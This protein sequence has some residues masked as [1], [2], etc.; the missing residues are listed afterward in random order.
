MAGR[1]PYAWQLQARERLRDENVILCVPTGEGKTYAACLAI[2]DAL[3]ASPEKKCIFTAPTRILVHQ[4][5]IAIDEYF[6]GL[7]RSDDEHEVKCQRVR[8]AELTAATIT[9]FN[10]RDWRDCCSAHNC[11]VGTQD[12]IKKVLIENCY[13]LYSD[14]SLF[15]IDECHHAKGNNA[16]VTLME[17]RPKGIAMKVLGL[18]ASFSFGK[19]NDWDSM[20]T[21]KRR[22][23]SLIG[24]RIF[25]PETPKRRE[26]QWL[27]VFF[28]EGKSSSGIDSDVTDVLTMIDEKHATKIIGGTNAVLRELGRDAF[29]YAWENG[30]VRQIE[31][32][33]ENFGCM[34]DTQSKVGP[35]EIALAKLRAE[36]P[37]LLLRLRES[38]SVLTHPHVSNKFEV[39]LDLLQSRLDN[40][41]AFGQSQSCIIFV[42]EVALAFPLAHE[43]GK[44]LNERVGDDAIRIVVATGVGSMKEQDRNNAFRQFREGRAEVMVCTKCAEEG[45][46]VASCDMVV[47]FQ[48]FD[49]VTSHIQGSGR[50]RKDGACIYYFENDP[51]EMRK[52]AETMKLVGQDGSIKGD[53]SLS[54][55]FTGLG[56]IELASRHPFVVAES[57][58]KV[59]FANAVGIYQIYVSRVTRSTMSYMDSVRECDL[60]LRQGHLCIPG[61]GGPLNL[62]AAQVLEFL[63]EGVPPTVTSIQ[64]LCY[65]AVVV[66]HRKGWLT[67]HNRPTRQA[68][69][70]TH[71][72]LDTSVQQGF[73]LRF[74]YEK[75]AF[76]GE[77]SM[78]GLDKLPKL[79]RASRRYDEAAASCNEQIYKGIR[80][81]RL[82]SIRQTQKTVNKTFSS[83]FSVLQAMVE[84]ASGRK[85]ITD[86]PRL[87]VAFNERDGNWY[88]A[89]NRRLFMQ[90]V[91]APFLS[92][93]VISVDEVN[94]TTE[95]DDK[96]DQ[97][98]RLGETWLANEDGDIVREQVRKI[99]D[100][101][102]DAFQSECSGAATAG[103]D[104]IFRRLDEVLAKTDLDETETVKLPISRQRTAVKSGGNRE[105]ILKTLVQRMGVTNARASAALD[106][107]L[108]DA[109]SSFERREIDELCEISP[110]REQQ[111]VDAVIAAEPVSAETSSSSA[112]PEERGG[113]L[114]QARVDEI[115]ASL[116]A[117]RQASSP[118]PMASASTVE[119]QSNAMRDVT[120]RVQ[121][122]YAQ[123]SRAASWT[124]P[125][126]RSERFN[127]L[128]R[129]CSRIPDNHTNPKGALHEALQGIC[130]PA[131]CDKLPFD[132]SF[133][134]NGPFTCS[135][136]LFG[137]RVQSEAGIGQKKKDAEREACRLAIQHLKTLTSS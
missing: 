68:A 67:A 43:L 112:L 101:G 96:C 86:F 125:E 92:L 131:D 60:S 132:S 7:H 100:D 69:E 80:E 84:L 18:T 20:A 137:E 117:M 28:A 121:S 14:V 26:P 70:K 66:L 123:P 74:G 39:L 136:K 133:E 64:K 11:F 29:L 107:V 106:K 16:L 10:E 120:F 99:I 130:T 115:V 27:P 118:D 35:L 40:K 48:K 51:D 3:R 5:T 122:N 54:K 103:G 12:V 4:Q 36:L 62:S 8:V 61:P 105:R 90:K 119:P 57:S 78:E 126:R 111:V 129:L 32:S 95:F 85:L 77:C 41:S 110:E 50:A 52:F 9:G 46:D 81:L 83:G 63:G 127:E 76:S 33:I 89:D 124:T 135:L 94:W 134:G 97:Q 21:D 49:T 128:V 30:I 104:D 72:G 91:V 15:V 1:S 108:V 109:G 23:E 82:D 45:V 98:K 59:S 42:Q 53:V 58:A 88:S 87:R 2:E 22:L 55:Q 56:M 102:L 73:R 38:D 114:S 17:G 24:G 79:A 37:N 19:A 65:V 93:E 25:Q 13:L 116:L 31:A 34:K 71:C 6:K 47:R 44:Y 113:P 75:D